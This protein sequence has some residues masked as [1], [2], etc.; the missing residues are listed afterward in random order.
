MRVRPG[1]VIGAVLG[2][3]LIAGG[4]YL[5]L[6]ALDVVDG[7]LTLEPPPPTPAPFPDASAAVD[8]PAVEAAV[9]HLDPDAPMPSADAVTALVD[10]LAADPR[11]GTSV[12]VMVTDVLTGQVLAD[13]DGDRA[14]I[15]A[16]TTKLLTAVAAD[17]AL[18]AD[19]TLVTRVVQ[20]EPGRIVLVGGGDML[21]APGAGNPDLVD[22]RAG[23]GDLAGQTAAALREAG[24]TSVTLGLDDS[25]FT[26]EAWN[27]GWQPEHIIYV[28]PT[29]ALAVD[30]GKT[31]DVPF[32]RRHDD[33]A[34]EA[35]RAFA[36]L[37]TAEGIAVTE[38][39]RTT[40]PEAPE[41][42]AVE[43]A[44]LREIVGYT[45]RESDNTIAEVLGR[46]VAV[47]RGQPG[48]T[49][50]ATRA[51]VA[52]VAGLGIDVSGVQIADCSGLAAGSLIPARVLTDVL[53]LA[54]TDPDLLP[55]V[56]DLPI[57]GW[58]GTLVERFVEGP[59]RGLVRA[60]TGSLP[61]VTSLAGTLLTTQGRLLA[62]AVL[63][64]ATPAGGQEPPRAAMDAFVGRLVVQPVAAPD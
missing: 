26:G 24:V 5:T 43:S 25:L 51:V 58:Q 23:L 32:A 14:R 54:A 45:I 10:A 55:V 2:L 18:G 17:L 59:A 44:P 4:G 27:P 39:V 16:S 12:G 9:D 50:A 11:M 62:F 46:L 21:L 20:P 13:L 56:V 57:S 30:G 6:D 3:V 29:A 36:A 35:A 15:P 19:R 63:A 37:L 60:K 7:P 8:A 1:R 48:T 31:R 49:A 40:A 52:E 61:N 34:L 53:V 28:A 33:P 22:G 47:E 64:D 38:P 41:I 42:A